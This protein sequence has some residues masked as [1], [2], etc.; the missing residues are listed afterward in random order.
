MMF[1]VW[2]S[3]YYFEFGRLIECF[4]VLSA[5]HLVF[6]KKYDACYAALFCRVSI[7]LY[8]IFKRVVVENSNIIGSDM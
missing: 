3:K 8:T 2:Q 6:N 1:V 7:I 4:V 5:Q